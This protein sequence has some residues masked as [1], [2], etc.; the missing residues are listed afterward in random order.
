MTIGGTSAVA[1]LWAGLMA[2]LNQKLGKPA[3]FINPILYANPG[4]FH[5]IV[6]GTNI[7]YQA[8]PGWDPCTGLG[9]PDGMAL[10]QALSGTGAGGAGGGNPSGGANGGTDGGSKSVPRR[11]KP[12]K[13]R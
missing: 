4:A 5:D 7:D 1:P 3:G 2:R 9:S 8:G 6:S 11:K 10:L 12:P 13:R